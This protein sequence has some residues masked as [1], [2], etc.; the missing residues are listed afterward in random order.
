MEA[1]TENGQFAASY[2]GPD[3]DEDTAMNNKVENYQA[4]QETNG[5]KLLEIP[6]YLTQFKRKDTERAFLFSLFKKNER[7]IF[8]FTLIMIILNKIELGYY[9]FYLGSDEARLSATITILTLQVLLELL[10]LFK[11]R[12]IEEK[13]VFRTMSILN[14]YFVF[15]ACTLSL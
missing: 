13:K 14:F 15:I 6:H 3:S 4:A 5:I 8:A 10:I 12:T 11:L 1:S 7:R 9:Y 2:D